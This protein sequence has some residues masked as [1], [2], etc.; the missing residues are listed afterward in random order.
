MN[1]T[2]KY[3]E[4]ISREMGFEGRINGSVLWKARERLDQV[5]KQRR[6]ISKALAA[7]VYSRLS[8]H[9]LQAIADV[10]FKRRH[11]LSPELSAALRCQPE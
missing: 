1:M 4:A 8:L 10:K 3:C 11:P 5:E 7:E 2:R 6:L 9:R